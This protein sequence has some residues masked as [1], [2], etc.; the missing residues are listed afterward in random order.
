MNQAQK[1]ALRRAL[2]MTSIASYGRA[3]TLILRTR[4]EYENGSFLRAQRADIVSVGA[5]Q[6]QADVA[7]KKYVD[8]FAAAETIGLFAQWSVG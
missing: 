2:V 3:R 8:H 1:T 5:T 4:I 7:I 6:A